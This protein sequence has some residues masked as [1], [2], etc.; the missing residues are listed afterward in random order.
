MISLAA[1]LSACIEVLAAV[2]APLSRRQRLFEAILALAQC[3]EPALQHDAIDT[4]WRRATPSRAIS[5]MR[6]SV[7]AFSSKAPRLASV[8][9][10]ASST[11]TA[12]DEPTRPMRPRQQRHAAATQFDFGIRT[13]VQ[14]HGLAH[15]ADS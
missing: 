3:G 11:R 6:V 9:S 12:T 7:I 2:T 4:A 5:T 10:M 13:G 14:H 15:F 1:D 8:R